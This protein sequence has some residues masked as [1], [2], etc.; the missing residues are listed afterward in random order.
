MGLSFTKST[1][2]DF[3][4]IKGIESIVIRG[5]V[6]FTVINKPI[7]KC[8]KGS[9]EH[10]LICNI[11]THIM[12]EYNAHKEAFY[13]AKDDE[14]HRS[15]VYFVARWSHLL[16]VNEEWRKELFNIFPRIGFFN[17]VTRKNVKDLIVLQHLVVIH[18]HLLSQQSL[19]SLSKS[20]LAFC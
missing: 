10:N 16:F 13:C 20:L 12:P 6:E 2:V 17:E 9:E 3:K 18:F 11:L 8:S 7:N 5:K 15:V 14:Y 4:L 1:S 19:V